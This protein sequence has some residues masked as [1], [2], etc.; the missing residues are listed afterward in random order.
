MIKD[1][2]DKYWRIETI[3]AEH[4]MDGSEIFKSALIKRVD[5]EQ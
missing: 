1:D 5:L 2:E 3:Q 4:E